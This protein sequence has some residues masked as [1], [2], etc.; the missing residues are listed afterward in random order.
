MKTG[1]LYVYGHPIAPCAMADAK[2]NVSVVMVS[3]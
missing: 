2:G 3:L 1:T